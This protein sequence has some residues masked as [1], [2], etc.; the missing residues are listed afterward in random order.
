MVGSKIVLAATALA[1]T[2]PELVMAFSPS[3]ISPTN[4]AV[5]G[6]ASVS[7]SLRPSSRSSVALKAGEDGG[8]FGGIFGGDKKKGNKDDLEDAIDDWKEIGFDIEEVIKNEEDA[9]KKKN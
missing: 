5:S 2:A 4:L 1:L 6:K 9:K 8:L 3:L 7:L